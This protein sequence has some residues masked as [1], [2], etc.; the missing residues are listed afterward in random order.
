MSDLL[1]I[2]I[3]KYQVIQTVEGK[4]LVY[5]HGELWR[6]CV[7]DNLVLNLAQRIEELEAEIKEYESINQEMYER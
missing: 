2:K 4:L 3:G 1:N 6:D 7:D 5:R